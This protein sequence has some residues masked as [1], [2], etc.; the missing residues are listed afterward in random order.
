MREQSRIRMALS[1]KLKKDLMTPLEVEVPCTQGWPMKY[2][3]EIYEIYL[4]NKIINFTYPWAAIDMKFQ[5]IYF[6]WNFQWE[7]WNL[8]KS[9]FISFK[10]PTLLAPYRINHNQRSHEQQT[11]T[12]HKIT[13]T[14]YVNENGKTNYYKKF[15]QYFRAAEALPSSPR[16]WQQVV[17]N[18]VLGKFD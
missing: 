4:K 10:K 18:L 12:V 9:I 5:E 8:L 17:I 3:S 11:G 7:V 14:M 16:K 13:Y 6:I 2:F 15:C 1:R